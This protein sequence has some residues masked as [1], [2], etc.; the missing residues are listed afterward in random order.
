MVFNGSIEK[1]IKKKSNSIIN[2]QIS[3]E[4]KTIKSNKKTIKAIKSL[5][6]EQYKNVTNIIKMIWNYRL[7]FPNLNINELT[8]C[9]NVNEK[10]QINKSKVYRALKKAVSLSVKE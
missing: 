5:K 9:I 8:E 10:L 3:N 2:I 1:E 4:L 7:K 6:K